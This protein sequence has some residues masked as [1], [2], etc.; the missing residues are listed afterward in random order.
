MKTEVTEF[1]GIVEANDGEEQSTVYSSIGYY[2][3]GWFGYGEAT[4]A[5]KPSEQQLKT[6]GENDHETEALVRINEDKF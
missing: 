4:S 6:E 2:L 1:V 3:G 5:E